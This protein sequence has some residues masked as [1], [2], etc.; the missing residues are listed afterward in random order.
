MIERSFRLKILKS[1]T[2]SSL[3][4]ATNCLTAT[5]IR[6]NNTFSLI[7]KSFDCMSELSQEKYP[8]LFSVISLIRDLQYTI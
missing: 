6:F 8:T 2:I 7:L 5:E 4:R 1:A 3:R